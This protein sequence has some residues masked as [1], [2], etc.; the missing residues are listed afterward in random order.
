MR[1]DGIFLD[2]GLSDK[3]AVLRFAADAFA[4]RGVIDNP[5][6][7][8]DG[9]TVREN[10]LS[11]GIGGGIGIPHTTS[12]EAKEGAI[13]LMRLARPIDFDAMDA[14]PVDVVL[15]LVVP[16]DETTLHLQILAGISRLCRSEDFL[17]AVRT[18]SNSQA[19]LDKIKEL[20][21][22]MAFF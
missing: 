19:L 11:T 16:N 15:V 10:V 3:D 4:R 20:E 9:M 12:G 21:E 6:L 17:K 22:K 7:L 13:L 2:V 14:L 5:K 1:A 18:T 8:Y